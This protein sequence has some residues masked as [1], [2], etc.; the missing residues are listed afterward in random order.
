MGAMASVDA[1]VELWCQHPGD[2]PRQIVGITSVAAWRG[3]PDAVWAQLGGRM[4][5]GRD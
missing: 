2:E 1:V 5:R 3:L 4:H